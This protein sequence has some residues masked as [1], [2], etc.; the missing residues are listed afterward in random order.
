M[1]EKEA[2]TKWCPLARSISGYNKISINRSFMKKLPKNC[3]CIASGCMMWLWVKD[4]RNEGYCGF[5]GMGEV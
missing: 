1:T 4:H 2:K 5:A 3:M